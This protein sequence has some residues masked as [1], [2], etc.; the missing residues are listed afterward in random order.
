MAYND[1]YTDPGTAMNETTAQEWVIGFVDIAG[2]TEL[3]E[4][5]GDARAKSLIIRLQERITGLVSAHGGRVQEVTGDE[6]L[7]R[8]SG[9]DPAA[10]CACAIQSACGHDTESLPLQVRIGLHAGPVIIEGERLFGDTVN[11]AARVVG[12]AQAGQI[13]C[14]S[15]LR[16]RLSADSRART[17]R[18][19]EVRVKGKR[20]PLLVYDLTWRSG[21]LTE[22]QQLSPPITGAR[23]GLILEHARLELTLAPDDTPF[24]IGRDIGC[25]LVV[26]LES[27]SR[28]HASIAF[29]RGHF[30]FADTSTNGCYVR[31]RHGE[32]L[33]LRREALP[34]SGRG[35]IALGN[36]FQRAGAAVIRYRCTCD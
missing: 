26:A 18:F 7:F 11:T 14:S 27:V 36:E 21:G 16:Q 22:I 33:Y 28:R 24:L 29:D 12:I 25:D 2:S 32:V 34:L 1:R 3:Y 23:P 13:I 9:A 15:S 10:A 4:R 35:E 20:Q 6:I 5:A 8:F 30:V 19:D 31:P 17:R